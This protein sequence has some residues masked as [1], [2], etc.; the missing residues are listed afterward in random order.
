M[1]TRIQAFLDFIA[2]NRKYSAHT[3]SN[4]RRDLERFSSYIT[5][6]SADLDW[7][8]IDHRM[9]RYF[10]AELT[11]QG[12]H[13]RSIARFISTLRS[14]W[15]YLLRESLVSRNPWEFLV[16]PTANKRLPE[17]VYSD[18]MTELLDEIDVSR[19]AGIRDR[20]MCEL[21]YSAG[22]RVSELVALN[23]E[24][25]VF[26]EQEIRVLHGKGEK[27]RIVLFGT[28]AKA[29]LLH[30]LEQARPLWVLNPG[31]KALFVNQ[32]GTRLSVRS[33][34]YLIHQLADKLAFEKHITPHTFR[35]SFATALLNGGADLRV[36][37]ELLGHTSLSTT[38]LYTHLTTEKLQTT[39][40]R[41][42]PRASALKGNKNG[43]D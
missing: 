43:N 32:T 11:N 40:N 5:A 10:L 1:H 16:V 37:Q 12:Y 29:W 28:I 20:T 42:H 13:R 39:Y 31:E 22:L 34:Q 17:V 8:A 38:Q 19:P 18:E 23:V 21:L 25:V 6:Q 14:F 36:V 9:C 2:Q 35:H 15:N 24:D 4:Y 41:A 33:V 30:Y 7:L 26:S 3:V 27:T